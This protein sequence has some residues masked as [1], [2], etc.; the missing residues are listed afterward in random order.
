MS[1]TDKPSSLKI[2]VTLTDEDIPGA[3]LQEPLETHA[4]LALHGGFCVGV[5]KHLPAGKRPS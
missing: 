1:L 3:K 5:L 2:T 4:I